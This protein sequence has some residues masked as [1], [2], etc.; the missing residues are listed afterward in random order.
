MLPPFLY[1]LPF[2]KPITNFDDRSR[3]RRTISTRSLQSVVT[4]LERF[5]RRSI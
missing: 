4:D 5:H 3:R 1:I 2:P